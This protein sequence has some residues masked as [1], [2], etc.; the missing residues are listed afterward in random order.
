[1]KLR[2]E[3]RYT[4]SIGTFEVILKNTAFL[5]CCIKRQILP[6]DCSLPQN[7]ASKNEQLFAPTKCFILL[8][9]IL[10]DYRL[11]I[12]L[13][14]FVVISVFL[15]ELELNCLS[16]YCLVGKCFGDRSNSD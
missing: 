10:T 9:L 3:T 12:Y 11:S 1:M 2:E 15:Y 4:S 8:K 14:Q 13:T 7:I 6:I 5:E 16:V